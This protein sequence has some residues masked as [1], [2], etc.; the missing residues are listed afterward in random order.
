SRSAAVQSALAAPQGAALTLSGEVVIEGL[1][2]SYG[3]L[4]ALDSVDLEVAPGEVFGLLGPNGAG[5][6]TLMRILMGLLVPSAGRAQ[7]LGL[8]VLADRVELKPH[9]GYLPPVPFF[10]DYLSGWESIRFVADMHGL[11]PAVSAGRA[12]RLFDELQ[13]S[14]AA[15]DFVPSYSLR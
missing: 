4:C 15:D 3:E 8:D 10:Y 6:T 5:K 7:L 9:I 14:E 12:Q 1:S 13:L 2:K 11:A